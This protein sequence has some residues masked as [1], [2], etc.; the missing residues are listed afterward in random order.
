MKTLVG[1]LPLALALAIPWPAQAE[2]KQTDEILCLTSE[3]SLH[4][5]RLLIA[6]FGTKALEAVNLSATVPEA[7]KAE[8][9]NDKCIYETVE[10]DDA[11]YKKVADAVNVQGEP[12]V[13]VE[14]TDIKRIF[15][16]GAWREIP[17]WAVGWRYAFFKADAPFL[18]SG[19]KPS[20][21][22]GNGCI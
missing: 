7:K 6:G 14:L 12:L 5:I 15:L 3:D 20:K 19:V 13:I 1:A 18:N 2:I 8:G 22:T 4:H 11:H 21:C 16:F 10:W 17:E 9:Q